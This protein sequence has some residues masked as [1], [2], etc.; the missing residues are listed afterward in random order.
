MS[1]R[2]LA[3]LINTVERF[4]VINKAYSNILLKLIGFLDDFLQCLNPF[5]GVSYRLVSSLFFGKGADKC[6][7]NA[8]VYDLHD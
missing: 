7:F 5:D 1:V 2:I 8:V 4:G 3:F 6:C